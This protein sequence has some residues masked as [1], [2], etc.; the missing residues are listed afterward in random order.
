MSSQPL[1]VVVTGATG[2]QGGALIQALLSKPNQTLEIYAVTRDAASGSSKALAVKSNVHVVEGDF[3]HP[4]AIFQKVPN[5]W[6]LFSVT[7]APIDI[8]GAAAIEERQGK[9]MT[10]A[11]IEAGVQHIVYTSVDRGVNSDSTETNIPHFRSKKHVEDDIRIKAAENGVSWTFVRPVAFMENLTADFFGKTFVAMWRQIGA[12][13]QLQLVSTKD[14]GKVAAEA[15]LNADDERYKNKAIS[16]AGDAVSAK[17]AARIFK[18]V[19][20]QSIPSTFGIFGSLL[21]FAKKEEVGRMFNWFRNEGYGADVSG[22]KQT[23]PFLKDF[24]Q[25]LAEESA[26]KRS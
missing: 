11:A 18:E 5:V 25:W 13:K 3:D 22:L 8:K 24:R 20:G 17:Q 2:K 19:T 7:T 6:G 9:A 15:L 4:E 23:F 14:I 10:K 16:L 1:Q 12:D 26:W 21:K